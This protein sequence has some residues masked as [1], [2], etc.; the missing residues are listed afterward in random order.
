MSRKKLIIII[1]LLLIIIGIVII[2]VVNKSADDLAL[3]VT[4][5]HDVAEDLY[6]AVE[7]NECAS[8]NIV[9]KVSTQKMNDEVL[10][11]LIFGQMKKDKILTDNISITDFNNSAKKL[12]GDI[13]IP[14]DIQDYVYDGYIYNLE[15]D[16]ITREE[17]NCGDKKY[18]SK[19]YGYSTSNN[20]IQLDVS[21]IYIQ[22]NNVY[23]LDGTL[24]DEY[25]KDALDKT[26]DKG[27]IEVYTYNK[28]NDDYILESV[29]FK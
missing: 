9:K 21:A 27:T 6:G 8:I 4:V 13:T 12:L 3:N 22:N 5:K 16:K 19:L 28:V 10:L 11:Y 29:S 25:N 26:L 2:C 14:Q 23:D 7:V 20:Q 24:L 1:V 15:K 18:V 17:Y